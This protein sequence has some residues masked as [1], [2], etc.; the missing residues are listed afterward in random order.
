MPGK[1]ACSV[2]EARRVGARGARIGSPRGNRRLR[3][4][5]MRM[6]SRRAPF[7]GAYFSDMKPSQRMGL[8]LGA[9]LLAAVGASAQEPSGTLDATF[10][11]GD[12]GHQ[13][14]D[15]AAGMVN[16]L[17]ALP[18]GRMLVGGDFQKYNARLSPSLAMVT[19]DGYLAPGFQGAP[20]NGA[21]NAV[22]VQPDGRILIAGNFTLVGN[23]QRQRIARLEPDGTLDPTFDPIG[24]GANGQVLALALQPDGKVLV[25]G[26][27]SMCMGVPRN[28]IARLNADGTL[29]AAFDVGTGASASV[30]ALALQPD[31][32][33]VIGGGFTAFNGVGR[34][35]LARLN[36][37]GS[38]D[39]NFCGN[40]QGANSTVRALLLR[41]DGRILIGGAFT[42][43]AG[44][45]R[46]RIARILPGGGIDALFDPGQGADLTV[47]AMAFHTNGGLI[48][49]GDFTAVGGA[50]RRHIA[51][52]TANGALDAA[53]AVPG[54]GPDLPVSA[55][56]TQPSGRIVVA[57][58][59]TSCSGRRL[60]GLLRLNPDGAVDGTFNPPGGANGFIAK[61]LLQ[62]DGRIVI[63]GHFTGYDGWPRNRVARLLSDGAIDQSFDPGIGPNNEVLCAALQPDGRILIGG[64]FAQVGGQT[65]TRIARLLPDGSLDESFQPEFIGPDAIILDVAVQPD[66][67]ILVGGIFTQCNG[68]PR[69]GI[70]RLHPDGS[71]DASFSIGDG[72]VTVHNQPWVRSMALLPDGD[73]LVA[74]NFIMIDNQ[75]RNTLARLDPDGGVDPGF[76]AAVNAFA[77]PSVVVTLANGDILAGGNFYSDDL[78]EWFGLVRLGSNGALARSYPFTATSIGAWWMDCIQPLAN[79]GAVVG[80]LFASIDGVIAG[81]IARLSPDGDV[82]PGFAP[83][84][85]TEGYI[86]SMALLPTG[87]LLIAGGFD[88][89]DGVGRNR[90]ARLHHALPVGMGEHGAAD[91]AL[92]PNPTTGEAVISGGAPGSARLRV[93][94]AS[95]RLHWAGQR[96]GHS[97]QRFDFGFLAPGAYFLEVEARDG[98]RALPFIRQ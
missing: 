26:L 13:I 5:W 77:D 59:F 92:Y 6:G 81:S 50:Q 18:D 72:M 70:V 57:G 55:I 71:L 46:N 3:M 53:F 93:R 45:P 1:G 2:A 51:R 87:K 30:Q 36:A 74:G 31:G 65:R 76:E 47:K 60:N 12:P 94:D 66:G 54:G 14:G 27:F 89:Y 17:A 86:G 62:P 48:V 37:D 24:L 39:P 82:D 58:A 83:V 85:G 75:V 4:Y 20:I 98:W 16:A 22:A 97:P 11:P 38:L 64:L 68:E 44:T 32:R 15:G 9:A 49:A 52:I 73:I 61:V 79:G 88:A 56:L 35:R 23:D 41:P 40:G 96:T 95:G 80:G 19:A 21:V 91:A 7:G 25:G 84:S 29:D 69:H 28:R 33:V 78:L 34:Q 43:Y 10:N 90:I 42:D 63:A 67:R 8:L